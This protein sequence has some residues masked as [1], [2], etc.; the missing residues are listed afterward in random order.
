MTNNKKLLVADPNEVFSGEATDIYF[1]RTK[2]V[3]EKAGLSEKKVRAEIHSYGF[4]ENYSWAVFSGVSEALKILEG[5]KLTVYSVP[6]G[7][8]F[9]ETYPLMLI[10]GPYSEL[11]VYETALLG[12]LRHYIS[13]TTR[14]ARIKKAAG[15]KQVI[16]FGLRSIHPILQPM[17]DKAALIGG[18]DGVSG[19]L[20]QKYLGVKPMGTMPHGLII[21]VGSQSEAWILFDKYV[22][23]DVPRIA[24]IDT[25]SDEREEAIIAAKTLKDKLYGVRLDTPGSRR[26]NMKRIIKE[27]RWALDLLGYNRVKIFVSGGLDENKIIELKE[28][29]DGF[30]VGTSIAFPPSIDIS[31]D[32][33]EVEENGTWVP[34]SK[35]GKLMGARK[36]YRCSM[37]EEYIVPWSSINQPDCKNGGKPQDMLIKVM[38]NGKLL[39]DEKKKKKIRERV[40]KQLEKIEYL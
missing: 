14:A 19:V 36:W 15:E 4:P 30:G 37:E 9:R 21:T 6:E 38:E 29:V 24:L 31:M 33:V 1:M 8:I 10:E 18:V 11:V 32:I 25:F 34:R 23:E 13:I 7:T 27:V 35:R 2:Q 40:K 22:E 12:L 28:L 3:L 26:G 5:K 16:F 20:S 39:V 17:A